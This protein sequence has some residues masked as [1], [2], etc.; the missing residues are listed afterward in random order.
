[1][2]QFGAVPS[3]VTPRHTRATDSV[4][5]AVS[6]QRE[7]SLGSARS[8]VVGSCPVSRGVPPALAS[9]HRRQE[10][11]RPHREA[12]A[13]CRAAPRAEPTERSGSGSQT[14]FDHT[15]AGREQ[16]PHRPLTH[17]ISASAYV[18]QHPDILPDHAP[19]DTGRLS[20]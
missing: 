15:P 1:M 6:R 8:T 16:L 3:T 10:R 18:M 9:D 20:F 14:H 13:D 7:A 5:A 17:T 12:R 11:F 19:G 4:N 2:T